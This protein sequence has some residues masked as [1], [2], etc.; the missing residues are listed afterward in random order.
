MG[1]RSK[2]DEKGIANSQ[3]ERKKHKKVFNMDSGSYQF[4]NPYN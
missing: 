3:P 1:I 2:I 4:A